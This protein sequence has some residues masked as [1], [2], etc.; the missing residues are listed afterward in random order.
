MKAEFAGITDP[1]TEKLRLRCRNKFLRIFSNGFYDQKYL[2]WERDHKWE[3][4]LAWNEQLN[5]EEYKRLLSLRQ[6]KEIAQR[7]VKIEG[8]TNLIFSFEK[9][10]LREAIHSDAGAEIFARGLYSYIY[11]GEPPQKKFDQFTRVLTL[12]PRKQT[13]VLTWPLQTFFLFIAQPAYHIFVNPRITQIAAEHYGFRFKYKS[14]VNWETYQSML[15]F[16]EQIRADLADLKPRDMIDLQS[17]I[18]VQG[19]EKYE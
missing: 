12:L 17:F 11:A 2:E 5:Q 18:C 13:R 14:N 4:H 8:S 7:A 15:A 1:V 6:Y 10:A 9:M 3:A 16:A 19:S